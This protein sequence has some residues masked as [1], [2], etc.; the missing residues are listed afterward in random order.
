MDDHGIGYDDEGE[1]DWE[2]E[3]EDEPKKLKQ[4]PKN[5]ITKFMKPG[6]P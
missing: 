1:D 4:E 2:D 5:S 6:V 3:E